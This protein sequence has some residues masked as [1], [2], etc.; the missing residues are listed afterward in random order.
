[1]SAKTKIYILSKAKL[2]CSIYHE[3]PCNT[4]SEISVFSL[5]SY[6][7]SLLIINFMYFKIF[8]LLQIFF[9]IAVELWDQSEKIGISKKEIELK[10]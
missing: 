7:S 2:L 3:I 1:M 10:K 4:S 6:A 5:S 8:H 9:N